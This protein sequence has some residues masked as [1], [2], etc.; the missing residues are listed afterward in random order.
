MNK[1]KDFGI[2]PELKNF[3]G[4]KI[5]SKR[6]F[7]K[8]IKVLD[9]KIAPSIKKPGTDF[10]TLQIEINNEKR[11]FFT[12]S[13]ILMQQIKSIPKDKFPFSTTIINDNEYFEFT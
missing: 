8:E 5:Q 12:G 13:T 3:T 1:F 10:L 4:E 7:D 2:K 6:I 9:Y 11:I